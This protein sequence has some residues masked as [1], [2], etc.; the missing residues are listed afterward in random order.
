MFNRKKTI[1]Q[2]TDFP[3]VNNNVD[4]A[5]F[6]GDSTKTV[7]E[8]TEKDLR[9]INALARR[10]LYSKT[11]I[12]QYWKAGMG[13]EVGTILSCLGT[14]DFQ[15]F[16][17]ARPDVLLRNNEFK[18]WEGRQKMAILFL[19]VSISHRYLVVWHYPGLFKHR[20]RRNCW[21][22]CKRL[23]FYNIPSWISRQLISVE[24]QSGRLYVLA[25]L[26][27]PAVPVGASRLS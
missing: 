14:F 20:N 1:P 17:E 19:L 10:I 7:G 8:F 2:P 24:K 12:L 4:V 26:M 16:V 9:P 11:K 6:L 3:K 13:I 25:H 23:S 18:P 21:S 22:C 5:R 27:L 15:G